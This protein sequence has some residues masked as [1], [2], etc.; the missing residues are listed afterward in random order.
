MRA[1]NPISLMRNHEEKQER[2]LRSLKISHPY[3]ILFEY[4][5]KKSDWNF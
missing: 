2:K 3:F 5:E 4:N 1:F